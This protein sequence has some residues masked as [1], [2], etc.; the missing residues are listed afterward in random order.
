MRRKQN[1]LLGALA[2]VIMAVL[3]S[4]VAVIMYVV[5]GHRGLSA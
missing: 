5:G 2:E 1:L 3:I 4:L